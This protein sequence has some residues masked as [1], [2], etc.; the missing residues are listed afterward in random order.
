MVEESL[1][2]LKPLFGE[3]NKQE[4]IETIESY[5]KKGERHILVG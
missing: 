3:K 1:D 4:M 5:Y 2:R